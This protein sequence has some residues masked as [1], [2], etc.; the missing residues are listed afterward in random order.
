[1]DASLPDNGSNSQVQTPKLAT[2]NTDAVDDLFKQIAEDDGNSLH[3]KQN[4]KSGSKL[5]NY[6]SFYIPKRY[7]VTFLTALG[8]LLVYAMRTNVG[9]TVVMILD[10]M[11]H[12]KVS[13]AKDIHD[14]SDVFQVTRES[15]YLLHMPVL[16]S[17]FFFFFFIRFRTV[18]ANFEPTLS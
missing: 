1:M 12:E 14:V 11:A 6:Y 5:E 4:E 10:D 2:D 3:R 8:M 15:R 7:I 13:S 16:G 17:L 18:F 9:V